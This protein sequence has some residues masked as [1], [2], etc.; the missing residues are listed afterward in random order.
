[1]AASSSS[2]AGHAAGTSTGLF[3][4]SS[5]SDGG[6]RGSGRLGDVCTAAG[7]RERRARGSVHVMADDHPPPPSKSGGGDCSPRI[8]RRRPSLARIQW[9]WWRAGGFGRWGGGGSGYRDGDGDDGVREEG[10]GGGCFWV[11]VL[12][13]WILF[14]FSF[15]FLRVGDITT[16]HT[17]NQIFVYGCATRI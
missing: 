11:R 4:S 14:F 2:L 6:G 3:A 16:P 1:M 12:L 9:R 7:N 5:G 17:K 15:L 10:G 13:F 8:W